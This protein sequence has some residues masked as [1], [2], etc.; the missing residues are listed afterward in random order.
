MSGACSMH[1]V[2]EQCIQNVYEIV[3]DKIRCEVATKDV[4]ALTD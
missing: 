1:E 4:R 3:L 2:N